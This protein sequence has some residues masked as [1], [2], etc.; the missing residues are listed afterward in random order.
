MKKIFVD[1]ILFILMILE[2]S[3]MYMPTIIHEIIGIML[4]VL[5]IIHLIL[6][7][8][9]INNIF[10]GKYSIKRVIMLLINGL[11]IIS[12]MSSLVMGILSSQDLLVFFNIGNM[13]IVSLHK[14]TAYICL[15]CIGLHLGI[16]FKAMFG[17]ISTVINNK[18]VLYLISIIIICFGIYSWIHLDLWKHI[19]GTYGFSI[20]TGNLFMNILEYLSIVLMISIIVNYIYT[21][22][23]K[24]E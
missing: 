19:I 21:K 5:V 16:N 6:N 11:F 2:Y 20:V 8:A 9:Y 10:K 23:G 12:F 3:R 1:I 24:G 18:I 7:R 17:K 14:I 15:I 22:I 4:L 13:N